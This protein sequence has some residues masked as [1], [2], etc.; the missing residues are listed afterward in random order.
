MIGGSSAAFALFFSIL[1]EIKIVTSY[2]IKIG[3]MIG[4]LER[5]VGSGFAMLTESATM[6]YTHFLAL[7]SCFALRILNSTSGHKENRKCECECP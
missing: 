5:S 6:M 4:R 1:L 7:E 3:M 2:R